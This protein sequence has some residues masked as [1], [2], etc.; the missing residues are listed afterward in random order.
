M[1]S[2]ADHIEG[3]EIPLHISLTQPVFLG[4]VPRSFMIVNAT[5]AAAITLGLH[6]WWLGIPV[7]FAAHISAYYLTKKDAHFF[8]IMRRHVKHPSYLES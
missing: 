6:V 4:G 7:G 2:N 1:A 5:I 3:Y 8:E